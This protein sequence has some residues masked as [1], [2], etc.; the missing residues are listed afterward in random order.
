MQANN[1]LRR[2]HLRRAFRSEIEI[3]SC[4]FTHGLGMLRLHVPGL[5][6]RDSVVVGWSVTQGFVAPCLV[7]SLFDVGMMLLALGAV[8]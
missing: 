8:M 6:S 5:L 3:V 7:W 1:A 4:R 2:A